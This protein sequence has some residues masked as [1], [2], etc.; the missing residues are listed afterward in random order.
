MKVDLRLE[1][2]PLPVPSTDQM[3]DLS[4]DCLNVLKSA[5]RCLNCLVLE[6]ETDRFERVPPRIP[7]ISVLAVG[8]PPEPQAI[9]DRLLRDSNVNWRVVVVNN[10]Q[11]GTMP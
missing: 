10:V 3:D 11:L 8:R 9:G 2:R 7:V 5:A 6:I 4:F 1:R